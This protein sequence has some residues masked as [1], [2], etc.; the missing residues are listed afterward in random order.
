[1]PTIPYLP[2]WGEVVLWTWLLGI[3][4]NSLLFFGFI[5]QKNRYHGRRLVSDIDLATLFT[6][7]WPITWIV[8]L[9]VDVIT[10]PRFEATIHIFGCLI[11]N[12]ESLRYFE[13]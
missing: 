11:R 9:L 10:K 2:F 7:I 6:V 13:T 12:E 3:V 1:M 5:Y 8:T 4:P